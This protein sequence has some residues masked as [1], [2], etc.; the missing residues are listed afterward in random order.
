MIATATAFFA[1]L[2]LY[3]SFRMLRPLR[4]RLRWKLL[5]AALM[6]PAVLKFVLLRLL[7]FGG[8]YFASEAPAWLQ[9]PLTWMTLVLMLLAALLLA[10]EPLK[11]LVWCVLKMHGARIG[12]RWRRQVNVLHAVL[13]AAALVMVTLGMRNALAQPQVRELTVELAGMPAGAAPVKLALLADL[14]ADSLKNAAFYAPIV[15]QTNALGADAVVIAGDFVDGNVADHGADL[16]PLRDLHAPMGVFACCGNHDYYS[17]N[18]EW[19]RYL[20]A[21]GVQVLNNEHVRLGGSGI[22]LAGVTDIA[23]PLL[24]EEGPDLNRAL[25]GVPAGTPVVL[26]CHQPRFAPVAAAHGRVALQLSGH[27][28][29][30]MVR[31]LDALIAA[32]NNG[33]VAGEYRVG[34]MVLYVSRGTNL[35]SGM[36]IRLGVPAEITLITLRPKH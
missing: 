30:G 34:N 7:P 9:L 29:G 6:L 8:R 21:H 17:G 25:N 10:A 12:R 32:S 27:T 15:A 18:G 35:W 36:L 26:L 16:E 19:Q 24:Q 11:L 33:Y 4:I 13:L 5:L 3:I 2:M 31:G 28:H 23:A 22:V 1:L 14:H 20:R